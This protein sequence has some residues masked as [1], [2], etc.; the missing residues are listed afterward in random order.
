AAV[1]IHELDKIDPP[2]NERPPIEIETVQ[3]QVLVP[4]VSPPTIR[5]TDAEFDEH[6]HTAFGSHV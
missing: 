5:L 4:T 3:P 1:R 2:H 6:P